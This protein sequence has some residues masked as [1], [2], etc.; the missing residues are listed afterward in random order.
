[1]GSKQTKL[2]NR[3]ATT[4]VPVTSQDISIQN[5]TTSP[6]QDGVQ[7]VQCL[8]HTSVPMSDPAP[9]PLADPH[10]EED[11]S[12]FTAH[13]PEH[14]PLHVFTG[15]TVG[16][17]QKNSAALAAAV[18]LGEEEEVFVDFCVKLMPHQHTLFCER[19]VSRFIASQCLRDVCPS[20][21]GC[22][23]FCCCFLCEYDF[24]PHNI[25]EYM[26]SCYSIV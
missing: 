11:V 17:G 22:C 7:S 12:M 6:Q 2:D 13:H 1:M 15:P 8:D 4:S 9:E 24:V 26:M 21:L 3:P 19:R 23:L 25:M 16:A 20:L 5:S 10:P 14:I 18:A